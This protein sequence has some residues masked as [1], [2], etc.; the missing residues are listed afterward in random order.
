MGWFFIERPPDI[1][2]YFERECRVDREDGSRQRLHDF[3]IVGRRVGYG[4]I[5]QTDNAGEDG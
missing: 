5:E 3:A 2:E 1:R 4:A